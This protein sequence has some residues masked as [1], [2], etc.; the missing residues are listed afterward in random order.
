MTF[1]T[2]WALTSLGLFTFII[3]VYMAIFWLVLFGIAW[4]VVGFYG[5]LFRAVKNI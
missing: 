3:M 5:K 2:V 4:V 1:A